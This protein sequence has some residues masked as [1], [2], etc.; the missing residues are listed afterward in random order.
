MYVAAKG[1]SA[2]SGPVIVPTDPPNFTKCVA[3]VRKGLPSAANRSDSQLRAECAALFRSLG[4]QLMDFLIRADWYSAEARDRQITV[5]HKEVMRA[6]G[7]DKRKAYPKPGAFKR[8]LTQSGQ[9]ISDVLFRVRVNLIY[10]RLIAQ[11][12]ARL[13]L[14]PNAAQT[15]VDRTTRN[16]W[17]PLTY[18][19][20]TYTM[21]DCAHTFGVPL[22]S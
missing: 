14:S 19:H 1:N 4:S 10:E 16:H 9:T 20:Q 12:E 2:G 7:Q 3:A 13:N 18:C 5:T 22:R 15:A 17:R 8:F 21:F 11:F 6:F